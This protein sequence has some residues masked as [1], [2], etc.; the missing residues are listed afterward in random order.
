MKPTPVA[1]LA[2]LAALAALTAGCGSGS[3]SAPV[4]G[5]WNGKPLGPLKLAAATAVKQSSSTVIR[6][7]FD[8]PAFNAATMI[9]KYG[10]FTA[11]AINAA[12]AD[13]VHLT[14]YLHEPGGAA[15][16]GL[17]GTK[18]KDGTTGAEITL[19]GKKVPGWS[20]GPWPAGKGIK[21]TKVT[22]AAIDVTLDLDDGKGHTLTGAFTAKVEKY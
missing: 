9:D 10:N 7:A 1:S 14:L 8:C 21:I 20:Y 12:C 19:Y 5:N 2:T 11:S 16:V 15:K 17:Y 22:D 18:S 6:T 3:G 13:V 4:Q